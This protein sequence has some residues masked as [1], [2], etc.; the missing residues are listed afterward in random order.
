[1][2]TVVALHTAEPATLHANSRSF[3]KAEPATLHA[4]SR[5]F[6]KAEPGHTAC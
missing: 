5:S 4:N 3:A 2:L 6:A 1:M